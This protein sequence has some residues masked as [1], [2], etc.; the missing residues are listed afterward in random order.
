VK[1]FALT[2]GKFEGIHLGHRTLLS[3]I[4]EQAKTYGLTPAVMVF[5][6]HPYIF[7]GKNP[8][9]PLYTPAERDI[10]LH[11]LGIDTIIHCQFNDDFAALSPN[12]FCKKV[13]TELHANIVIVG[14][15]FCFGKGRAGDV[16]F[17]QQEA[18][19]YAATVQIVQTCSPAD[20]ICVDDNLSHNAI[21]TS[22]IRKML[23]VCKIKEANQML[24][25]PFFVSG[26]VEMGKQLGRTIGFPT[27][28]IYAGQATKY[29]PPNGVYATQTTIRGTDIY[30]SITNIG[31]RPTVNDSPTL[32]SIETFLLNYNGTDLYGEHVKV[33]LLDFIRAE[34]HFASLHELKA[35]IDRDISA[36]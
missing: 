8:Y 33:E 26:I 22:S 10:I 18:K 25:S 7:F 13:F 36:I 3:Q 6:P 16:V 32:P 24:G 34:R 14:E 15:N 19:K 31:I 28:N 11:N 20:S 9:A 5:E 17:L 23:D 2:I 21:S 1:K 29:L 27:L 12:D 4:T 35:Q 30:P